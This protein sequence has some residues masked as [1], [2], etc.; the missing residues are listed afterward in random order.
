[1]LSRS[2]IVLDEKGKV[3]YNEQVPE[4]TTEPNYEAALNSLK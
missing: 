1:L 3:I 4:T 2:V